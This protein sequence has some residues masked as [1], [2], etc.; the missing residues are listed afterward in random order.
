M[1]HAPL[2]RALP[3][4]AERV[5]AT[6]ER[7]VVV[8]EDDAQLEQLDEMLWTYRAE[9]F[10]PHGRTG[11]QPVLLA[12]PENA[13]AV[14]GNIAFADG[15]WRDSALNFSRAFYFFDSDTREGARAAWRGLAGQ[16]QVE[17]HYWKQDD[18]GK[19]QEGP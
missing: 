6:G 19:W 10:L 18:A 11:D 7:L 8:A 4:I 12:L 16:T 9:S 13:N 1:T 17:R 2:E 15:I 5:V 3:A 14:Y